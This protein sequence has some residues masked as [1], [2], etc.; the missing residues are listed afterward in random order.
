M[1]ENQSVNYKFSCRFYNFFSVFV[2]KNSTRKQPIQL[3]ENSG[4]LFICN[5]KI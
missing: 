4:I 3:R 1:K 5:D 2:K